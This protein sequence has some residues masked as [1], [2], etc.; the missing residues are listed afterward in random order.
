MKEQEGGMFHNAPR[1]VNLKRN[2]AAEMVLCVG[3]SIELDV[4][5]EEAWVKLHMSSVL[6]LMVSGY[7]RNSLE[8]S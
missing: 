6:M 5:L 1:K 8:H 3:V 4:K 2:N 7:S